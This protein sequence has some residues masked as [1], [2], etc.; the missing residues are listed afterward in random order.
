[1]APPAKAVVRLLLD[2]EDDVSRDNIRTLVTL[3]SKGNLLAILHSLV[4]VDVEDLAFGNG[5]LSVA[6]LAPVLVANNLALAV[7]VGAD[8]LEALNHRTHLAHHGLHTLTTTS[9]TLLDSALLAA[10]AVAF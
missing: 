1:M 3:S 10:A 9:S 7:T 6:L 4:D 5:L 8:G 2:D